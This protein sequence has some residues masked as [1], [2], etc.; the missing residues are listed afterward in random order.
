MG[1][2]LPQDYHAELLLIYL[3]VSGNLGVMLINNLLRWEHIG[4]ASLYKYYLMTKVLT[5]CNSLNCQVKAIKQPTQLTL[6]G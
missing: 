3:K 4:A 2:A 1:V 5:P 6:N